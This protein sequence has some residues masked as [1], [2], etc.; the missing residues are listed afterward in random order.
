MA[1]IRWDALKTDAETLHGVMQDIL[2]PHEENAKVNILEPAG[3]SVNEMPF[4]L[5]A[6]R[7]FCRCCRNFTSV[8]RNNECYNIYRR[9][10]GKG[11]IG[12]LLA[13]LGIQCGCDLWAYYEY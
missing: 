2:V 12:N 11:M 1:E 13:Q 5:D 9:W 3:V 7:E 10:L 8:T 4:Y 6:M